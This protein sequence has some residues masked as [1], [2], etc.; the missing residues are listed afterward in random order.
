LTIYN[1]CLDVV[2]FVGHFI[3]GFSE[4]HV[5]MT[6][7]RL[8]LLEVVLKPAWPRRADAPADPSRVQVI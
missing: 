5:A 3:K 1:V 6:R 8:A 7:G 4:P 2:E